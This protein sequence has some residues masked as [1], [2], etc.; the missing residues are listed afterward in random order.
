MRTVNKLVDRLAK[1]IDVKTI[2]TFT[3]TAVFAYLAVKHEIP[4][5]KVYETFLMIISFYFGTQHKKKENKK[6]TETEKEE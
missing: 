2:V 6:E 5:D 1:L 3:I 4:A